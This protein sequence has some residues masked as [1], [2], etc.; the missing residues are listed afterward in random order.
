M[1]FRCHTGHTH[2]IEHVCETYTAD[3]SMSANEESAE[4]AF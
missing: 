4:R 3:V 1:G 2:I